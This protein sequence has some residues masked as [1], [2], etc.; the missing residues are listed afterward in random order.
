M[1]QTKL[2]L[3]KLTQR[4]YDMHIN[5]QYIDNDSMPKSC[6]VKHIFGKRKTKND[7]KEKHVNN[8]EVNVT[9]LDPQSEK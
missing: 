6:K 4:G 3:C 7:C 2:R 8:Y 5:I 9:R 1:G